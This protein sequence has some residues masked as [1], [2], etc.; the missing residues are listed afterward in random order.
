MALPTRS[1]LSHQENARNHSQDYFLGVARVYRFSERYRSPVGQRGSKLLRPGCPTGMIYGAVGGLD[2]RARS[3]LTPE[4]PPRIPSSVRHFQD[5]TRA[6]PWNRHDLKNGPSAP[7]RGEGSRIMISR[8]EG[9]FSLK[10]LR[11]SSFAFRRRN[12]RPKNQG[13]NRAADPSSELTPCD[14]G[15]RTRFSPQ[16]LGRTQTPHGSTSLQ[17]PAVE[18]NTWP[19]FLAE[20][21]Q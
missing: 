2:G 19:E 4:L 8:S 6:M 10:M 18:R 9:R 17:F 15:P 14:D 21:T 3:I 12:P 11:N 13:L 5:A 7:R 20:N 16:V 1:A